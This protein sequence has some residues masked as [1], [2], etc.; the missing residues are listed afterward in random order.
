M[1]TLSIVFVDRF[2]GVPSAMLGLPSVAAAPPT[3]ALVALTAISANQDQPEAAPASNDGNP[4]P[5]RMAVPDLSGGVDWIN[6]AGPLELKD[7]RGK[8][9]LLDFWT[10]CCINCM[11]ILPELKKLEESFPNELV[12]IGVHSAK[13]ENEEDSKNITEAVLRYEIKHPV[14]NDAKHAIWDRFGIRSWPTAILIDPEG[15]AVYGRSGEFKANEFATLLKQAIPYYRKKGTLDETPLRFDLAAEGAADTPLRFPGKV[16][17]DEPGER[18]FIADSNHNRIV[19]ADFEGALVDVIGSGALGTTDGEFSAATFNHPQ[20]MALNGDTLY[21]A[22]TENHMLRKVD[23]VKRRV[24]TIAGDGHQAQAWPGMVANP[25]AAAEQ[26][27]PA[28]FAGPPRTTELNSPW[29]LQIHGD[30]LYI[31]MAGPHQIWKMPLDESE[32]S[33]YAGNSR[34]D[35]VDGPLVPSEPYE[36]GYAS[37]AQPSGLAADKQWLYVADSE[38]SSLRAVP[39]DPSKRVRTVIGTADLPAGRLFAFGDHD[40]SGRTVRLQHP[41]GIALND[42][43]LYIADTYNNK[44]KAVNL[45]KKSVRTIVGTGKPGHEDDPA[46]FDEPAGLSV[47]GNKLYV[48]DTNNHLIRTVDLGDNDR[49]ATFEIRGLSPPRPATA[50]TVTPAS[51]GQEVRIDPISLKPA[52]GLVWLKAALKL[53][54]GY[55]INPIAP[56]RYKLTSPAS[57]GPVDRA[58]LG[59][60]TKVDPPAAEFQIEL[61]LAKSEGEETIEATLDYYYCRDGAEGVCKAGRVT[62]LVPLTIAATASDSTASLRL[63]VE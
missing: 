60:S 18:L 27:L 29:D 58:A 33:I 48:A 3:G 49:V 51:R 25:A 28:R 14:V 59:R 55:K 36:A 8:F 63:T 21:V 40:G 15:K 9:V 30:D 38:G 62:W 46:S 45:A 19:I 53:P 17:A 34:E 41:L 7:L 10:Y 4:F 20:G 37:F 13:F 6:T 5:R 50:A 61:P 47:A 11:H 22:D 23:L 26:A 32:I 54:A 39:F 52:D 43:T 57:T 16:L 42:G 31:A 56:M 12:V 44:I 35:I 2:S 1:L 24:T